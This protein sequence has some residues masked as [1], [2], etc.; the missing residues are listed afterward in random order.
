M[1]PVGPLALPRTVFIDHAT[2]ADVQLR[3]WKLLETSD[4]LA[5]FRE[6]LLG[7]PVQLVQTGAREALGNKFYNVSVITT[8][9]LVVN[10]ASP[11]RRHTWVGY[12]PKTQA[13]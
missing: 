9:Q 10:L 2:Y 8:H 3:S 1:R 5:H 12:V 11:P 6:L 13:S 4:A 7:S